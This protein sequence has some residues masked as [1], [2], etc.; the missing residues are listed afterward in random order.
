MLDA[1]GRVDV[2]KL[3]AFA[4]DEFTNSY[5]EITTRAGSAFSDG[6]ALIMGIAGVLF[7]RQLFMKTTGL[8]IVAFI[9]LFEKLRGLGENPNAI[10]KIKTDS[11]GEDK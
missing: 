10:K 11:K 9:Y 6:K 7:N 5:W 4:Y 8:L 2:S 3:G 1:D